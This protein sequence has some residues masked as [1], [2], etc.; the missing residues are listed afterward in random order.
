MAPENPPPNNMPATADTSL[1]FVVEAT[2]GAALDQ[3]A[4]ATLQ[5]II[6][7]T[8]ILDVEVADFGLRLRLSEGIIVTMA[9]D[10][11]GKLAV[12]CTALPQDE[13]CTTRM[14][15]FGASEAPTAKMLESALMHLREFYASVFMVMAQEGT[16][17]QMRRF[18]TLARAIEEPRDLETL[19]SPHERLYVT[20]ATPG[21]FLI[22]LLTKSPVAY[23]IIRIIAPLFYEEGRDYI[24]R[25]M[26][27]ET[28][29]KELDVEEKAAS[30][31][32]KRAETLLRIG[33]Q[34][35]QIK[36]SRIRNVI[37][38]SLSKQVTALGRDPARLSLPRMSGAG[39]EDQNL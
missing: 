12:K 9:T 37:A 16:R 25:K 4:F 29:L 28:I 15:L 8:A 21:S 31:E 18:V 36:D 17:D 23:R 13:V 1:T 30:I 32:R 5:T 14:Q 38:R 34:L 35:D 39:N 33:R 22:T 20:A 7:G 19:L 2:A 3:P 10:S 6:G 24:I 26:R 11:D 27:A